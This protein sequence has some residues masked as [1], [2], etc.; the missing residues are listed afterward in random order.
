MLLGV[1]VEVIGG[2]DAL[3]AGEEGQAIAGVEGWQGTA[4]LVALVGQECLRV[5]EQLVKWGSSLTVQVTV[6]R[7]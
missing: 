4:V 1:G 2:E 3:T 7:R 6:P 5:L